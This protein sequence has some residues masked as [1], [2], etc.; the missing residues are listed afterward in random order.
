MLLNWYTFDAAGNPIWLVAQAPVQADVVRLTAL[1]VIGPTFMQQNA[2]VNR[3]QFAEL[4]LSFDG[5]NKGRMRYPSAIGSG[6]LPLTRLSNT[7]GN[8]CTGTLVDDRRTSDTLE[9]NQTLLS[10]DISVS[11]RYREEAGKIRFKVT[12][13]GSATNIG[14]RY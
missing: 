3:T 4:E 14:N 7:F 9:T 1:K 13:R 2:T 11:T 8:T 12:A 6:E 5:C 10:A